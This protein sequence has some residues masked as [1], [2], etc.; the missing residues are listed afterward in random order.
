MNIF[1]KIKRYRE[2][3]KYL[4]S[5]GWFDRGFILV[6]ITRSE[7]LYITKKDIWSISDQEFESIKIW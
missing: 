6:T 2:R 3:I 5:H 7:Y 4:T 1:K